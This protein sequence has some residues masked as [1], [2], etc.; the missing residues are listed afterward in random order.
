MCGGGPV[1]RALVEVAAQL[2]E[3]GG[4]IEGEESV[5]AHGLTSLRV[6]QVSGPW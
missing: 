4:F 1:E 6:H 2:W 5:G 3:L